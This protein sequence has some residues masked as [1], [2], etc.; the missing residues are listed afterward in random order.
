VTGRILG[1]DHGQRRVGLAL[2]DPLGT[3]ALPL[4]SFQRKGDEDVIGR[5]RA[6]VAEREVTEIVIGLPVNMDGT[7]GPAAAAIRALGEALEEALGVP[8]RTQDER[9]TSV[10]ADRI[11]KGGGVHGKRRKEAQ[12]RLAA[13]I[14]LQ[15]YLDRGGVE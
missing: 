2:S 5:I 9:L 1:I 15:A 6:V 13:Q 4:D 7:E 8:V 12:D 10:Q 3:M 14:I 11:L